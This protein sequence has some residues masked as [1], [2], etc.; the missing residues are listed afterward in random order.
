MLD[1]LLVELGSNHNAGDVSVITLV[2]IDSY[3]YP[4]PTFTSTHLT[5]F[6]SFVRAR[7][8]SHPNSLLALA[9]PSYQSPNWPSTRPPARCLPRGSQQYDVSRQLLC[10]THVLRI[11][12][13]SLE[14]TLLKLGSPGLE[15]FISALQ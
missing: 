6:L 7:E 5:F 10:V 8:K 13:P 4:L 14:Q 11:H 2:I 9:T 12:T 1:S 3:I 15:R